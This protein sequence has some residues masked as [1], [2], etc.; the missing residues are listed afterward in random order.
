L[1][2]KGTLCYVGGLI[3]HI[4]GEGELG[5]ILPTVDPRVS[6]EQLKLETSNF[7]CA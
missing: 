4:V 5:K 2:G 7:A 6:Q 1:G 3:P